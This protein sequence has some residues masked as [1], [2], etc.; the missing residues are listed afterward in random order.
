[1]LSGYFPN[2]SFETRCAL[3]FNP[4]TNNN[5]IIQ[6][7]AGI[8]SNILVFTHEGSRRTMK[9]FEISK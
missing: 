5:T 3:R 4:N 7:A 8:I 2:E 6:N 9:H 1:M